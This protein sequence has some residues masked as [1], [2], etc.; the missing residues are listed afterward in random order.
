MR[1]EEPTAPPPQHD[2]LLANALGPVADIP[3]NFM[4]VSTENWNNL[5]DTYKKTW[6]N[7]T[8]LGNAWS[9]L[10]DFAATT[11]W[12]FSPFEAVEKSIAGEP[13][14]A[15][16][17][18]RFGLTA[19]NI[20]QWGS[21]ATQLFAGDP[22]AA[23]ARFPTLQAAV[24]GLPLPKVGD[25]LQI[26]SGLA[27]EARQSKI[28]Q[29]IEGTLSPTSRMT[30]YPR[31][32]DDPHNPG[33]Q[34]PVLDSRGKPIIDE[35]SEAKPTAQRLIRSFA[36][37]HL[38]GARERFALRQ[39]EGYAARLSP[40]QGIDF[41]LM[42][43]GEPHGPLPT[44]FQPLADTLRKLLD[45]AE[46]RLVSIGALNHATGEYWP[47]LFKDPKA[48]EDE[49]NRYQAAVHSKRPFRGTRGT[50]GLKRRVAPTL[51]ETL[52]KDIELIT[53]NPIDAAMMRLDGMNKWYYKTK[54][55]NELKQLQYTFFVPWYR[56]FQAKKMGNP[57]GLQTNRGAALEGYL[58][59]EDK[60]FKAELPP[61]KAKHDFIKE[62]QHEEGHDPQQRAG[63]L[64][65]AKFLGVDFSKPLR[66]QDPFLKANPLTAGYANRRGKTVGVFGSADTTMMHEMGHQLDYKYTLTR[67]FKQGGGPL[68]WD[69]LGN[70]A[71]LRTKYTKS[72]L[73]NQ[74]GQDGREYYRYLMKPEERIANMWHAYWHAPLMFRHVAPETAD[75]LDAWLAA[76]QNRNLKNLVE[77][78]KPSLDL[79]MD[80]RLETIHDSYEKF[81]PG[82]RYLGNWY[83]PEPVARVFNNYVNPSKINKELYDSVRKVGTFFNNLQ[84][85]VSAFHMGMV[86]IDA[87]S[88]TLGNAIDQ[89]SHGEFGK[90]ARNLPRTIASQLP[91]V[92]PVFSGVTRTAS[93]MELRHAL[94]DPSA[95]FSSTPEF[96]KLQKAFEAAGARVNMDM[97]HASSGMGSLWRAMPG[98]SKGTGFYGGYMNKV[99]EQT[100]R[101]AKGSNDIIK[102]V[103]TGANLAGRVLDTAMDPIMERFVPNV[104]LGV[105]RDMVKD[106]S[107]RNPNTTEQE[108]LDGMQKIWDSVDNRMGQL[109]YDNLFWS[110]TLKDTAF[111]F[112]RAVGWNLGTERE[113][114]GG[115]VDA[116]RST[117]RFV[118]SGGV[119]AFDMTQRTAYT[120]AFPITVAIQGA[121]MNYLY[122]WE[123]PREMLDYFF[124]R[125][126]RTTDDGQS[127]QRVSMPSYVKDLFAF[128]NDPVA[129]FW[130][131]LHPLGGIVGELLRNQDY[132][133]APIYTPLNEDMSRLQQ[134][135]RYGLSVLEPFSVKG[136]F[137]QYNEGA[138]WFPTL[139]SFFGFVPAP[140][141]I[142][143]PE[144]VKN[145]QHVQ[146]VKG[147]KKQEREISR[148]QQ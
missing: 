145:Y 99:V 103:R 148:E 107:E 24:K 113:I 104:K 23:L 134:Y 35:V 74:M 30:H 138:D 101:E 82:V 18:G 118:K 21:V 119:D 124:P 50:A 16:S 109:V 141:S 97:I 108:F 14:E 60:A 33:K 88:S 3:H 117:G 110:Q 144:K 137:K 44:G 147:F 106:W 65:L 62:V 46:D 73:L 89:L 8:A 51:Q 69:E 94:L 26:A 39:F 42:M 116:I 114:G 81:F 95:P 7:E 22:E 131:K 146:D 17:G 127:E 6:Q 76:P 122:T 84:L 143:E 38:T 64:A 68:V 25:P 5:K 112:V 67:L 48:A 80:T 92:G 66:E 79:G 71:M 13:I 130:N 140:V 98:Y 120:I 54:A 126:G 34:I 132:A 4:E 29:A 52:D 9:V 1:G 125:T 63:L 102:A 49:Y 96:A 55:V 61:A 133:G 142:T 32:M 31:M 41:Q 115:V 57:R 135:E 90:V 2:G 37:Q 36:Q 78:I 12:L 75:F 45:Q 59:L 40:Q 105:F 28:G 10:E 129:T 111:M 47:R 83:A 58:P 85:A 121:I 77:S 11:N 136:F 27:H 56:E 20:G 19:K 139:M 128:N 93:G 123:A 86:S 70:L 72:Q 53:T 91:L 87:S 15:V 43:A 100:F